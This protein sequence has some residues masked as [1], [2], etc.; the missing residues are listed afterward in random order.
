MGQ[1]SRHS[2][3][4]ELSYANYSSPSSFSFSASQSEMMLSPRGRPNGGNR[5]TTVDMMRIVPGPLVSAP[6]AANSTPCACCCS[7]GGA[8]QLPG[9][10]AGGH[11]PLENQDGPEGLSWRR[12]HLCR[13]KLKATATTSEL[14]S[15]F[16]MVSGVGED[17]GV[18][19]GWEWY[20]SL[21][22]NLF[23]SF[24]KSSQS[25]TVCNDLRNS[26]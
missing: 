20:F 18:E 17:E 4:S 23:L 6:T 13:A 12:L 21:F 24:V 15:G 11:V 14:L 16:A 25:S 19:G 1:L 8:Q 3:F 10:S 5:Y 2:Q 22:I 7:C 26:E 9:G